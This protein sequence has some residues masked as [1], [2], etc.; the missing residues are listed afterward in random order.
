MGM[1]WPVSFDKW[2]APLI[3]HSRSYK[4]KW[5][6]FGATISGTFPG[7]DKRYL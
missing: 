1:G 4:G 2:K 7:V 3:C 6:A 5:Q